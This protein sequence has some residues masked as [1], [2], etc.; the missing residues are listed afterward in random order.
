MANEIT[1][2]PVELRKYADEIGK[3]HGTLWKSALECS[4]GKG[5]RTCQILNPKFVPKMKNDKCYGSRN[6]VEL[7]TGGRW[8]LTKKLIKKD[9]LRH[10]FEQEKLVKSNEM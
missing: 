4:N 6:W 7:A 9:D 8:T 3:C 1:A 10:N 2:N 5:L